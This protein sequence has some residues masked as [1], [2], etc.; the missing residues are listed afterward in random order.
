MSENSP[1]IK[2][3]IHENSDLFWYTPATQKENISHELLVEHILNYGDHDAIRK[4]FDVMGIK[5]VAE[6]FF[7]SINKSERRKGNYHELTLNYF[8]I[9]FHNYAS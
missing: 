7:G 8:T 5:N 6:V 9:L 4:L 1:E 2:A 3:F